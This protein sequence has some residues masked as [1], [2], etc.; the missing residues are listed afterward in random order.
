MPSGRVLLLGDS[1]ID[2][3]AYVQKNEPGVA[4]QLQELLPEHTVE[5]RAFD[6]SVTK[7]VTNAQTH[8]IESDDLAVISSGGN[9]AL[10]HLSLLEADL[11]AIELMEALW[12][13]REAFRFDYVALLSAV[14]SKTPGV[15]VLTIYN[16][17]FQHS[18]Q[19]V[20]YQRAAECG[21]A[22]FNDVIQHEALRRGRSVLELRSFFEAPADYANPIEPSASGGAKLADRIRPWV[23]DR[24]SQW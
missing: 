8:D 20:S 14:T 18:G 19:D 2:N 12:S 24:P 4:R 17:N 9:D 7:D 1:I 10:S 13:A 3:G 23:N 11:R 5:K 15:L 21:V 16:P 6:G 22:L